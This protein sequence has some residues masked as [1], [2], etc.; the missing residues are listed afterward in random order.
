ML[1]FADEVKIFKKAKSLGYQEDSGFSEANR[2]IR[3]VSWNMAEK[4]HAKVQKEKDASSQRRISFELLFLSIGLI[5]S[6]NF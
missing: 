6:G 5:L 3:D 4:I 2:E 1:A